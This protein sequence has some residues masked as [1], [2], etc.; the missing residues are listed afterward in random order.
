MFP[1]A[2]VASPTDARSLRWRINVARVIHGRAPLHLS[3]E[4]HHIAAQAVIWM[5]THDRIRDPVAPCYP[6][7]SNAGVGVSIAGL[8]R[9]FMDSPSHRANVLD[10]RYHTVGT[11]ARR[12]SRGYLWVAEVF[13]GG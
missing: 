12:D 3:S 5:A 8:H 13:C 7:G 4:L 6:G 9:A 10:R 11:A 2:G 1:S